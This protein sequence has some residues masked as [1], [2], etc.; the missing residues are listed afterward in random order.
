MTGIV[1][2]AYFLKSQTRPPQ[3]M[4]RW[5]FYAAAGGAIFFARPVSFD[6]VHIVR[7]TAIECGERESRTPVKNILLPA[8]LFKKD[9]KA[10]KTCIK[11]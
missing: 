5:F 11:S 2:P 7:G 3:P 6:G 1:Y 9:D 4:L 8:C 10:R